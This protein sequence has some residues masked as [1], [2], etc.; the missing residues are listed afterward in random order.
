[1]RRVRFRAPMFGVIILLGMAGCND[2]SKPSPNDLSQLQS[3]PFWDRFN[4]PF[5]DNKLKTVQDA[6]SRFDEF[7]GGESGFSGQLENNLKTTTQLAATANAVRADLD[8]KLRAYLST[9]I[10]WRGLRRQVY[11]DLGIPVVQVGGAFLDPEFEASERVQIRQLKLAAVIRAM[12]LLGE[13]QAAVLK[14][15]VTESN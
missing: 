11:V 15:A 8:D 13:A 2:P 5:D 12:A 14:R 7:T 3:N 1:M 10:T 6:S 9:D 4:H